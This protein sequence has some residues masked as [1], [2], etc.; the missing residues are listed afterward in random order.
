[1]NYFILVL[2]IIN[3]IKNDSILPFILERFE[4]IFRGGNGYRL[5]C[6]HFIYHIII[7]YGLKN[8][9]IFNIQLINL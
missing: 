5:Y 2:D 9:S 7:K 4:N 8:I 1:M 3:Y 6:I